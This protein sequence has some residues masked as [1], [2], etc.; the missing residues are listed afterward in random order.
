MEEM[1]EELNGHGQKIGP[2]LLGWTKRSLPTETPMTGRYCRLEKFD[3]ARHVAELYAAFTEAPDGR[4]WTYMPAGPFATQ[5]EY[6]N[7]MLTASV[8]TDP[9]HHAIL[10]DDK[11][12]GST[13]LMRIDPDNG[14]MEVGHVSYSRRLQRTRAGSEA[15]FLLMRRAFDELGYRRYEWKCDSLNTPS[16]QAALREC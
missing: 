16:R 7:Y 1:A 10:V 9:L 2:A 13:A 12:V 4:D 8:K 3:P 15:M 11:P 6:F 5:D 14:V